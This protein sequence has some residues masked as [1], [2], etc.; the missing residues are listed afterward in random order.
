MLRKTIGV[1]IILLGAL[2]HQNV[3]AQNFSAN[4]GY[5]SEYI[6]RGIPQK[7]SSAFAGA[8]VEAAGF[9]LGVWGA[10]VGDGIEID[11]YGG[12][13]FDLGGFGFSVGATYYTFTS[14]FDDKYLEA[15]LGISWK[16]FSFAMAAGNYD[17]FDRPELHYQFY[18]FTAAHIGFYG[19]VGFFE[20]EFDGMY[21]EAGYGN[22]LSADGKDLLDYGVALIHSNDVLLGGESDTNINFTISKIFSF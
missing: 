22:T 6:Y 21:Y 9:N 18:S 16:W 11:Y 14:I 15:N 20:D 10:D 7:S 19:T 13:S 2:H 12:Y 17:N 8:D 3:V 1:G 4:I 5:N